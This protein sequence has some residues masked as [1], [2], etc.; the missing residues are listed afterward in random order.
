M[1][2]IINTNNNDF[3]AVAIQYRVRPLAAIAAF[4]KIYH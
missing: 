4:K 3:I 1:S 2:S